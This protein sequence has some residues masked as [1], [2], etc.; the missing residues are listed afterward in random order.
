MKNI[1]QINLTISKGVVVMLAIIV[2][3]WILVVS[4]FFDLQS[5]FGKYSELIIDCKRLI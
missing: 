2:F 3:W 4:K 5:V 1:N